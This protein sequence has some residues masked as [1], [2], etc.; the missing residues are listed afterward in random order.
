[1]KIAIVG[2]GFVGLSLAAVLSAKGNNVFG[3]D[4]DENKCTSIKKGISPFFEPD[5]EKTLRIGLKKN[6]KISNNFSMIKNVDI[7]F[8]TVGTPQSNSGAIE[9]SI[10]KNAIKM[11][12]K[13]IGDSKKNQ[14]IFIKSTVT[15]G[16]M[17][18]IILPILE[19]TSK[20]KAGK[21]FGL[22]SNPEF[23]Q[24]STAIKDTKYPHAV[25]LGGYQTKFMDKAKKIFTKFH[26][27]TPIIVTNHQTAEM[28]KYAN[29]SFLATKISFINQLSN[30]CQRIP[31]A[32]IDDVAK[33]IGLDPRI[34]KLF[35]NAGPGYGGSCLPKDMKALINFAG[36]VG[37]KPTLLNAVEKTNEKQLEDI[38]LK[39]TKTLGKL[40][41]KRITILGTSFKPDTDDIRDSIAIELIKKL[42]RK[43]ASIT[44]YDPK[45]IENTKKV[46]NTKIEYAE[47]ISKSLQKSEC[48]VIM[49]HWKEFEIL[50]NN[51]INKMKKKFIIDC[52]RV[53]VK[54]ELHAEYY[55]IGIGK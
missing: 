17:K 39:I 34:G 38:I 21:D 25:V 49:V 27:N 31:G 54:K 11:I 16:S 45:A 15:P 37:I 29:N 24:E 55:A 51:L 26:P 36:S 41:N 28:I 44:I 33:T 20:R 4:V 40:K 32:N 7:I 18:N 23:L 9:L 13:I 2:L 19:K 50:N 48:I 30:I 3:I 46:F 35:L 8:V 1:M 43:Q 5:L 22:I 14:I 53:L 10:M 42:L 6:L 12:G 47:S 52:R